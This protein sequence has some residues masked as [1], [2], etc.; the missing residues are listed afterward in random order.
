MSN[1]MKAELLDCFLKADRDKAL[2]LLN[3][4]AKINS[5]EIAIRDLMEPALVEFG[6]HWVTV[7]DISLA[8]AYLAG[9]VAEEMLIKVAEEKKNIVSTAPGIKGITVLGNIE[10]DFHG[11]GRKLVTTFL[12]ASGWEVHDLGNDVLAEDFIEKAIEVNATV[13]GVSAMMYTTAKNI[14]KLRDALD[15]KN[16]SNRIKLAVGGA[17]FRLRST[18]VDEVGGDGTVGN[19]LLAPELFMKLHNSVTLGINL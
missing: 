1:L 18:L 8:H 6:D 2:L 14:K 13:I 17:V 9:K 11:L 19:A 15:N 3:D 12:K 10:D 4:Y 16:L 5:F 7:G